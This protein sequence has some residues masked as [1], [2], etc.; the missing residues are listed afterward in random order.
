MPS[1]P[2]DRE[3][4]EEMTARYADLFWFVTIVAVKDRLA[5]ER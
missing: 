2:T 5:A 3:I 1:T 4:T